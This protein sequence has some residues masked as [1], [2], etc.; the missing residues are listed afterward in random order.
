MAAVFIAIS[1]SKDPD[2]SEHGTVIVIVTTTLVFIV[3]LA[4]FSISFVS[5]GIVWFVLSICLAALQL[6]I[7]ITGIYIYYHM[8]T[9]KVRVHRIDRTI[10]IAFR[11]E[12]TKAHLSRS[13]V[14]CGRYNPNETEEIPNY[15]CPKRYET[16]NGTVAF[17]KGCFEAMLDVAPI[18]EL[19]FFLRNFV[20]YFI[21][22][23]FAIAVAAAEASYLRYRRY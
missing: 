5:Q 10:N 18:D 6:V 16:C 7:M 19:S 4:L 1:I 15:C 2:Y 9:E 23:G 21:F 11:S 20:I 17:K 12:D 8:G 14:C 3:A 22:L 13:Y